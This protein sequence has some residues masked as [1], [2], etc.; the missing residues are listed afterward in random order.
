MASGLPSELV[1][2]II[3]WVGDLDALQAASLV[4]SVFREACQR[5]LFYKIN[6][7]KY[8]PGKSDVDRHLAGL[9]IFRRNRSLLGYIRAL[10]VQWSED[11]SICF[12]DE[13][14]QSSMTELIQLIAASATIRKFS[15]IGWEG[16]TT[17]EFQHSVVA[18]VRSVHLTS[19]SLKFAPLELVDLVESPNLQHLDLRLGHSYS[20]S[21][22]ESQLFLEAFP[23]PP[24][25]P[26]MRLDSLKI[27]SDTPTI[28][29]LTED[30]STVDLSAVKDLKLNSSRDSPRGNVPLI[31]ARCASSLRRLRIAACVNEQFAPGSLSQLSHLEELVVDDQDYTSGNPYVSLPSLLGAL[32]TPNSLSYIEIEN[33]YEAKG[34]YPGIEAFWSQLDSMLANRSRFPRLQIVKFRQTIIYSSSVTSQHEWEATQ[35]GYWPLLVEAGVGVEINKCLSEPTLNHK[36]SCR[37]QSS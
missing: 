2:E 16:Q 3:S 31:I 25:T 14:I 27:T 4:S 29:F 34:Y 17:P 8:R 1:R 11:G 24:T 18:L 22:L 33:F 5:Q 7:Y 9:E 13:I 37:I 30:S 32:P 20:C 15:F 35:Q 6:I 23:P 26:R 10:A 19:L 21:P 36:M 28:R 12:D